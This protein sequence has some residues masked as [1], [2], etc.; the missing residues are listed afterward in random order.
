MFMVIF[1]YCEADTHN[2]QLGSAH[3]NVRHIYISVSYTLSRK[4]ITKPFAVVQIFT[5]IN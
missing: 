2:F 5:G 3:F 1:W 4:Q